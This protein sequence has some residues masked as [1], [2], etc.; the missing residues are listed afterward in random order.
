MGIFVFPMLASFVVGEVTLRGKEALFIYRKAP[1][2]VSRLVKAR[3][4]H[5]WIVAVPVAAAIVA[6]SLLAI[7]QIQLL[8]LLAYT[9]LIALLVSANVAFAL[10]IALMAPAFTEKESM[11]NVMIVSMSTFFI[12]IFS[13]I[14]FGEPWGL[15][16]MVLISWII[17]LSFLN[18]GRRKLSRI[19]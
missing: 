15:L 13:V 4:V 17:G 11:F 9:G 8:I 2:G 14:I 6:G 10:G 16:L 5:G 7:P 18:L 19:E 12:F 3:L 1:S